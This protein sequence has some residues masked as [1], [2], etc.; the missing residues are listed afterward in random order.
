MST[1]MTETS[2]RVGA[3]NLIDLSP[4]EVQAA[5]AK[6]EIVLVDVR[7]PFERAAER[8]ERSESVPLSSFD[9]A[10]L[11]DQHVGQRLVF[12]C[13]GGKRSADAAGRFSQANGEPEVFHL[14]GG[15]EAWKAV[16]QPV[17]RSASAPKVDVMRQ[18]QM[19]AGGLV[20]MGCYWA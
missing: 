11:R 20:A 16:G 15:I 4:A 14:A 12:H 5:L 13:K 8:I 19:V 2:S 6:G 7:E 18:V 10:K 17:G 1:V 9:G 3:T